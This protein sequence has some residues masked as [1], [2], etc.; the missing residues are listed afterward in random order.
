MRQLKTRL[1][2]LLQFIKRLLCC[3]RSKS[4]FDRSDDHTEEIF[5]DHNFVVVQ[6][7][8]QLLQNTT[9]NI[10]DQDA[11][12]D[13]WDTMAP[14]SANHSA[15]QNGNSA[16]CNSFLLNLHL[17]NSFY[18]CFLA[19]SY[20]FSNFS[21]VNQ[22]QQPQFSKSILFYF[23]I[24]SIIELT[25]CHFTDNIGS[26][27]DIGPNRISFAYQQNV[28]NL[29]NNNEQEP[30]FFQDMT[31]KFRKPKTVSFVFITTF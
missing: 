18:L 11:S 12:F 9:T 7:N 10:Y 4:D 23:D 20:S 22:Q 31:P 15:H 29:S 14:T 19:T 28:E 16:K 26:K 27:I 24:V 17:T 6:Q 2:V 21:L 3:F 5:V 25:F 8:D 13:D 30:D 1:F